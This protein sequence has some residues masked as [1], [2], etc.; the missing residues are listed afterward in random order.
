MRG[1]RLE[2][3]DLE[4]LKRDFDLVGRIR[5]D[6]KLKPA[7]AGEWKG[8]CPFHGG[9]SFTVAAAKGFYH[10]YGCGAHG[11]AIDYIR[12]RT[13]ASFL[14]A[15][16][17]IGGGR[18][19]EISAE[20]RKAQENRDRLHAAD[21]ARKAEAKIA[22]ALAIW[23][24]C[25]AI[26]GTPAA[27]YLEGRGLSGPFPPSL[28]FAE[29]L[30]C[31]WMIEV[32]GAEKSKAKDFPALIAGVQAPDSSLL[33]IHR[34]YLG[35]MADGYACQVGKAPVPAGDAKKLYGPAKGGAV[36]LSAM[37]DTLYLTEGIETGL[38][39]SQALEAEGRIA[40]VWSTISAVGLVN[41]DLG[42][43]R[44]SRIIVAADHDKTIESYGCG[45]GE[46]KAVAACRRFQRMGIDAAWRMLPA[47]ETDWLDFLAAREGAAA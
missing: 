12:G 13:G 5:K 41:L 31:R 20:A 45:T 42:A 18:E 37:S 15:V 10:C 14:E 36:R 11:D 33:T 30:K 39:V 32:D 28:R 21:E 40:T 43:Y 38:A 27:A 17:E 3:A 2:Q 7:G 8:E 1:R 25:T 9:R 46:A 47:L 29:K 24:K 4:I 26:G 22:G 6:V 35:I 19:I 34:I 44:P 23:R 16:Q